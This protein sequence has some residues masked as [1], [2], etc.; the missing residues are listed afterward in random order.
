MAERCFYITYLWYF[1]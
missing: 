1:I